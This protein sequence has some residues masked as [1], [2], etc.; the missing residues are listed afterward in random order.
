MLGLRLTTLD[1]AFNLALEE[2]LLLT[3]PPGHPGLFLL[4]RNKPSVIVGRHQCAADEVNADFIARENIPK[5][6]EKITE[7]AAAYRAS[8]RSNC[9]LKVDCAVEPELLT[10]EN[11]RALAQMEPCG[12]GC[13]VPV[14]FCLR[15][16][17]IAIEQ[18]DRKIPRQVLQHVA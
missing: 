8:G 11:I 17:R 12:T 5:F 6:R 15:D 14:F 10:I 18:R 7:L 2:H 9:A 13:P 3:L 1:P 4:W 16:V